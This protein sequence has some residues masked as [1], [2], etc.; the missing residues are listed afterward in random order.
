MKNNVLE[1][2]LNDNPNLFRK[3]KKTDLHAHALLS[4][5]RKIFSNYFN[6]KLKK[7][8]KIYNIDSFNTFVKKNLSSIIETIHGQF[9]LY[10]C[11]IITAIA[12]GITIL[13]MSVDFR[14]VYKLFNNSINDY[15]N[16]LNKLI[17]KYENNIILHIDLGI[18]RQNYTYKDDKTIKELINSGLFN[19]IDIFGDELSTP[20]TNR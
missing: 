18:S 20:R 6:I 15:I 7:I 10:E 17:K 9:L 8:N 19:G 3:L 2:S 5:N 1:K 16:E 14:T 13:D 12:D 4:S 11:S